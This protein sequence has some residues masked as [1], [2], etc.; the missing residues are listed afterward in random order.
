MLIW[1]THDLKDILA[2]PEFRLRI[3]ASSEV[4]EVMLREAGISDGALI[5]L[6]EDYKRFLSQLRSK[7]VTGPVI[8]IADNTT[9]VPDEFL[10]PLNALCFSL[11]EDDIIKMGMLINFIFRLSLLRAIPDIK[12]SPQVT[13]GETISDRPEEDPEKIRDILSYILKKEIPIIISFEIEEY[14][15]PVTV[16]GVCRIRFRKDKPIL[17]QFNPLLLIKGMKEGKAIKAVLPYKDLNYE[18]IMNVVSV[19]EHEVEVRLPQRLFIERR[20][21]VRVV[22]NI[23]RPVRLYLLLPGEAT[24]NLEVVD[25]S[26]RGIGFFTPRDLRQ[27]EVYIFGIQLPDSLKFIMTCG[28]IRFKRPEASGFRYGAEF[29]IHPQDEELIVQYIRK[30]EL[31]ILEFLKEKV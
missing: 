12:I 22:P 24:L 7:G 3:E 21:H 17:Y 15:R 11:L 18:G 10:Y 1:T 9:R 6:D 30:R 20:R 2:E 26:Q 13:F 31:E 16:R 27:Q 8:F 28:I 4:K 23:K 14:G 19:C 29:F 5:P 25:I